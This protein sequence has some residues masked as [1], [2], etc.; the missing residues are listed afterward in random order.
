MGDGQAQHGGT[1]CVLLTHLIESKI[2]KRIKRFSGK[3]LIISHI[4]SATYRFAP[5]ST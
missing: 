3:F 4:Y 5:V 1:I 2:L